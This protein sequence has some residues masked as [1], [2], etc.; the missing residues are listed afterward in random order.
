MYKEGDEVRRVAAQRDVLVA[1]RHGHLGGTEDLEQRCR[2]TTDND[3]TTAEQTPNE[4]DGEGS[5][6]G[7]KHGGSG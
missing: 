6:Y 4:R 5:S 2:L 1:D 3:T 7:G